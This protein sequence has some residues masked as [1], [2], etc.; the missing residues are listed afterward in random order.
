MTALL[1]LVGVLGV[2]SSGPLMAGTHAPALAIAWWRNALAAAALAPV[3]GVARR[4]EIAHLSRREVRLTMLAGMMLA[5][6]FATWVT[7]LKLT[8][9]ASATAL[10]CTQVGWVVLLGRL[11]GEPANRAVLV[12]MAIAFGGV[13]VVSGVDVTVSGRALGG[14]LLAFSGGLFAAVYTRV[15]SV[16]RATMSTTTY[17]TFCYGT[18]AVLL[19][20]TCVVGRQ[21][22][23]GFSSGSW[24]AIGGVTIAAQLLGHSVFNHLLAVLSPTV[25]SLILLLE[26][27]GASLLAAAFLRQTPPAGLY[28]GLALVLIGLAVVLARWVPEHGTRV[29]PVD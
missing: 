14:D 6:H 21:P 23:V 1:A 7:A 11:R 15:G 24:L 22:I 19:L 10:V 28:A 3:A 17:T 25:V 5:A 26:V 20:L 18:C 12:G 16:A 2:S 4:Q 13:L 27:P 8:S 9:V 29:G